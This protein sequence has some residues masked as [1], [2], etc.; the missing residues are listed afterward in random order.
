MPTFVFND[1]TEVNSYGFRIPNKGI[2]LKRFKANPVMLD[3]HYNSTRAVL[4]AWKNIRIE[5][6]KLQGD[7]DF[8]SEDADAQKI[9]GKVERGY[10]KGASMGVTFNRDYMQL[11][12]D[13]TWE[14][15]KCELYEVSI[16]AIPSNKNSLTL[17]AETGEILSEDAIKLS[18]SE[19]SQAQDFTTNKSNRKMEKIILSA[20]ALVAMGLSVAPENNSDLSAAIERMAAK[21]SSESAALSA[22]KTAHDATK[23]ELKKTAE[24]QAKALIQQAKLE[25]KVTADEEADMIKEATENYALTARMLS[26]I[27]AKVSL[28]GK[29]SNTEGADGKVKTIDDFEKLPNEAKL[30]FKNENPEAYKAL[31][32]KA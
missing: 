14:L 13:G 29:L 8:D 11:N 28:A 30:A 3:Q 5:D 18:I 27:P 2:N 7:S 17:F 16:V 26:K 25:G 4:G 19:L 24:A 12:P 15:T 1:E 31:F 6:T 9:E 22:E 10:I 21:L 20:T 23:A 32:K